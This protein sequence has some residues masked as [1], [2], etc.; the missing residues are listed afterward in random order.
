MN[1]NSFILENSRYDN[2]GNLTDDGLFKYY[3]DCKNR[4]TDV[5]DQNDTAVASYSYDYLGRRMSKTVY[6]SPDVTTKY[7]YDGD[8]VIAE[9]D[10]NDNLL[11]KFI[12]GPGID[13]PICTIDVTDSNAIYYY[14]IDG[15]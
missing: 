7:C 3:Y 12:Y 15:L 9:Y 1:L 5:N 8:Q 10:G 11:R 4:L 2:N 6:G 14:H 13:E